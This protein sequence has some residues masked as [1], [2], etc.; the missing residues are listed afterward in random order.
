MCM[1]SVGRWQVAAVA[2]ALYLY[3]RNERA[4]KKTLTVKRVYFKDLPLLHH[5]ENL[6]GHSIHILHFK[7]LLGGRVLVF[8]LLLINWCLQNM[9]SFI[10]L[11]LNTIQKERLKFFVGMNKNKMNGRWSV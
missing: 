2:S 8:L 9:H 7:I 11:I 6:Y 5:Q 4:G 10:F 3:W 1:L